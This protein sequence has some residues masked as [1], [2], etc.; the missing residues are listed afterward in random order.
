MLKCYSIPPKKILTEKYSRNWV[1]KNEEKQNQKLL[2]TKIN[3]KQ[4]KTEAIKKIS[5]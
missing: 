1:K 4:G 2:V 3:H 5:K